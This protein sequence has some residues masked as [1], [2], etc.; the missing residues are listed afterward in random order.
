M[1]KN[2][3]LFAIAGFMLLAS[4]KNSNSESDEVND[5]TTTV[6]TA[7]TDNAKVEAP[8]NARTSFETQYPQ[9]TNVNWQYNRPDM[10]TFD[11]EW[12]GWPV[13]DASDYAVSYNWNGN[14][15]WAWYDQDGN[16]IGTVST[17]AD[18]SSLPSVVNSKV[19]SE[20]SG[21]TISSVDMENDKDRTAYE[22]EFT[23]GSKALIDDKGNVLKKKDSATDTKE[24]MDDP[25]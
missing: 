9:A 19:K 11:W 6:T 5:T 22:I 2:F 4:C 12:S 3:H 10:Y 13:M 25:Q 8:A 18:H 24:K 20:F 1:K 21:K 14:D 15:Y 23:D 7:T 16:W 17:V